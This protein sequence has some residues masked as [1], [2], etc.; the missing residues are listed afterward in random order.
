M[1]FK[2]QKELPLAAEAC[3]KINLVRTGTFYH[4]RTDERTAIQYVQAYACT[5]TNNLTS[6][7]PKMGGG[8]T[9][10]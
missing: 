10:N 4:I 9:T 2:K 5:K 3:S 6:R 1:Y 8:R 7:T